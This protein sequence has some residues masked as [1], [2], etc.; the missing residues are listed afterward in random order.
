MALVLKRMTDPYVC[1]KCSVTGKLIAY[2]DEYY[3]DDVDGKIIDFNYYYDM[4]HAMKV[5]EAEPLVSDAMDRYAYQQIL[6]T[7][8]RQF[9]NKTMFDRPLADQNGL[10]WNEYYQSHLIEK[11]TTNNDSPAYINTKNADTSY[12]NHTKGDDNN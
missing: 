2:G 3:E 10:S 11:N 12:V 6:K 9:L 1:K 7:K 8:E 4:K 5:Q